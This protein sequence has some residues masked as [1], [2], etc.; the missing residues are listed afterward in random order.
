MRTV[1]QFRKGNN[2]V[3]LHNNVNVLSAPELCS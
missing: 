1:F 2:S 3:K